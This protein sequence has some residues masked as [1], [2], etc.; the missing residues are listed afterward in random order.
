MHERER[1]KVKDIDYN[2]LDAVVKPDHEDESGLTPIRTGRLKAEDTNTTQEKMELD[3]ELDELDT[4]DDE[5]DELDTEDDDLDEL[6]TEDDDLDELDNCLNL[7]VVL[8]KVKVNRLSISGR[9][10]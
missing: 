1:R 3:D 4:E 8:I 2:I 6:D 7:I 10:L 9:S 5:L